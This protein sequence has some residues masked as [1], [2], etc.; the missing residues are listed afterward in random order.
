MVMVQIL[1]DALA[2]LLDWAPYDVIGRRWTKKYRHGEKVFVRGT[3]T[4]ASGA[5]RWSTY[6]VAFDGGLWT[7][8]AKRE[9]SALL[10]VPVPL[11]GHRV[12]HVSGS[13]KKVFHFRYE[14]AQGFIEV[15]PG[16]HAAVYLVG[17]VLSDLGR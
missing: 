5:S 2:G 15:Y 1:Q 4:G 7:A 8:T 9:D 17:Q 10:P 11:P 6:L 14:S 16:A 3:V 12:E 13:L